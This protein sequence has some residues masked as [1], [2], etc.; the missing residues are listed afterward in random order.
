[1]IKVLEKTKL[2]EC[3]KGDKLTNCMIR[4]V[5]CLAASNQK[6]HIRLSVFV[7]LKIQAHRIK[8]KM[9]SLLKPSPI[10]MFYMHDHFTFIKVKKDFVVV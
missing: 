7:R 5:R 4:W 6:T 1:M 8:H 10:F 3:K 9:F 2:N